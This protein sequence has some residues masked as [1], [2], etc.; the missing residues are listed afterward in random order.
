MDPSAL[1]TDLRFGPI[2]SGAL[3]ISS[4]Y[5]VEARCAKKHPTTWVGYKVHLAEAREDDPTGEP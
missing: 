3:F 1:G 2:R 5:D 4:P